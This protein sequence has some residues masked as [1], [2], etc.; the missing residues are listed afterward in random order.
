VRDDVAE[1][2]LQ[3]FGR[4]GFWSNRDFQSRRVGLKHVSDV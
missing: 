2:L 4:A 1:H 3:R